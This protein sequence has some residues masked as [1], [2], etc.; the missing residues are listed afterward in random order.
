[1]RGLADRCPVC[2]QGRI[3]SGYLRV[4]PLCSACHAPLGTARADDAPPYF[5]IF[6]VGHIII[7]LLL[8]TERSFTPSLWILMAIF[9]PLTTVLSL[10]VIRPIKGATVGLM[11]HFGLAK[12]ES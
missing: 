6:L 8:W 5:T 11:L 7:P 2:G 12:S 1:M 9:L 3:F 10:A 4:V